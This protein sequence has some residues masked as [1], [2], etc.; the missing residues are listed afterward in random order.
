MISPTLTW[1]DVSLVVL[2]E[3]IRFGLWRYS[4]RKKYKNQ[5]LPETTSFLTVLAK[6]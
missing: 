1:K 6:H 2:S 4:A 5:G 3:M